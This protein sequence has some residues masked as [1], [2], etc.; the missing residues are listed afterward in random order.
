M[1]LEPAK[2]KLLY[3]IKNKILMSPSFPFSLFEYFDRYI[4]NGNLIFLA[5][6]LT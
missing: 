3:R 6:K 1:R 4:I 2:R 5:E